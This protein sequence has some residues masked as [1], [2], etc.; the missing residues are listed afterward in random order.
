[1]L[2]D[3]LK[4]MIYNKI[5]KLKTDEE[6]NY[7]T[8]LGVRVFG[9]IL[10]LV[11]VALGVAFV[12][13]A[14]VKWGEKL[15]VALLV[16]IVIY[17]IYGFLFFR[18]KITE[19]KIVFYGFARHAINLVE[20]DRIFLVATNKFVVKLHGGKRYKFIGYFTFPY[21]AGIV[22]E[23]FLTA[24]YDTCLQETTIEIIDEI[25]AIVKEKQTE[26]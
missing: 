13:F 22:L 19:T 18:F 15:A 2:I 21:F 16:P 11:C 26:L 17:L 5:M 6:F 7:M 25:E 3:F 20:I 12:F 4:V 10:C 1:M 14:K 24:D 8:S 23:L 9:I